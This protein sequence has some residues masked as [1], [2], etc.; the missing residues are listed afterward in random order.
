MKELKG[1]T[2]K[3]K[4][5]K[6]ERVGMLNARRRLRDR[7]GRG[8]EQLKDEVARIRGEIN[9]ARK[10]LKIFLK[11][12]ERKWWRGVI[13][14]C[15]EASARGR[16]GNMYKCL[17]RL[18]TRE[19]P[20]TRNM[21]LTVGEFKNHFESV[22]KDRYEERPEVIERAVRGAMDLRKDSRAKE[23][24][25][26]LNVAPE[27]EEIREAMK[28][29]RG[30]ALGLDGVRI[31]YIRKACEDIQG[32]VIE[33]VQRMFEVR[34]NEWDEL[35]KVGTMVPLLKKGAR[36]QVNNFREVCLLSTYV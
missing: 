21:K 20:A 32:R 11:G 27:I 10:E 29:T 17:R 18:R 28:E 33:I 19:R 31:G 24:K 1:F 22:S 35:V 15:E 6:N 14:E 26:F 7:R 3:V 30:S 13:E 25:E 23:G 12:L 36:D 9:E 5:R 34:A 16:I 8:M 2:E 4:R